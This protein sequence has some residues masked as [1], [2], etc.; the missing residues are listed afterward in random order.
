MACLRRARKLKRCCQQQYDDYVTWLVAHL[1]AQGVVDAGH[2][3]LDQDRHEGLQLGC[4]RPQARVQRPR[5][6]QAAP[7]T[8]DRR[9]QPL[10]HLLARQRHDVPTARSRDADDNRTVPSNA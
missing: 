4:L 1:L 2:G 6:C 9:R 5:C 3:A 8:A 7:Q 10:L